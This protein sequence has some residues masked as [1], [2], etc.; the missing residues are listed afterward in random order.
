MGCFLI[1]FISQI[2]YN[3]GMKR[4]QTLEDRLNKYVRRTPSCWIWT[5]DVY[6]YGYGK[7][8]VGK[9][10]QRRA[11]RVMYELTCGEIPKGMNVL[12]K[13]DN[14][15]CVNPEHLFLG[16]QQDNVNDM[17]KKKRGGYKT[18]YGENHGNAKLTWEQVDKMRELW[19]LKQHSQFQLA[20]M[21]GITQQV[22]SKVVNYKAWVKR[23]N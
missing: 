1:A 22:V 4:L 5:Q 17:M 13:C 23:S 21:Y 11:H 10:K 9:G 6:N 3:I 2:V 7:L 20:D 15:R 12:H 8:S 19:Q 16:T 14:P 18:F